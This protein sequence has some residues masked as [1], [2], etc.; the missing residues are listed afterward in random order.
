MTTIIHKEAARITT[1]LHASGSRFALAVCGASS[2]RINRVACSIRALTC[3]L[4]ARLVIGTFIR[5][6]R[7]RALDTLTTRF[8]IRTSV[9]DRGLKQTFAL[10]IGCARRTLMIGVAMWSGVVT[11]AVV[12]AP[13]ALA[14]GRGARA[15]VAVRFVLVIGAGVVVGAGAAL[16]VYALRGLVARA[17]AVA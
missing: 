7:T 3:R 5:F 15:L 17:V 12:Q 10:D 14:F 9:A 1:V 11:I 6:R 2:A 8:H 16:V 13:H 4:I